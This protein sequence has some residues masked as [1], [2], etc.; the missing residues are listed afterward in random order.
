MKRST[1]ISNF[2][3]KLEDV[4]NSVTYHLCPRVNADKPH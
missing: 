4:L 3:S 2:S 1:I